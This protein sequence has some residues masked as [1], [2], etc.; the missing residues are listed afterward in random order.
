[1]ITQSWHLLLVIEQVVP[2]LFQSSQA[3]DEGDVPLRAM[4][5]HR[6]LLSLSPFKRASWSSPDCAHAPRACRGRAVREHSSVAF[7][8]H[9]QAGRC[10]V[11]SCAHSPSIAYSLEIQL[12]PAC[13]V[14]EQRNPHSDPHP[15]PTPSPPTHDDES[16]ATR[17]RSVRRG[18]WRAPWPVAVRRI[19]DSQYSRCRSPRPCHRPPGS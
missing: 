15:P 2:L 12:S 9:S 1:M 11:F 8:T 3:A 18:S 6:H 13:A 10:A 17:P 7:H 5:E 19:A 16:A 4:S 14:S